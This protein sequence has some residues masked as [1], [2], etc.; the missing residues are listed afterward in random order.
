MFKDKTNRPGQILT[1][2]I[3]AGTVDEGKGVIAHFR[4]LQRVGKAVVH[5]AHIGK[6]AASIA[7]G[8][9][10]A[11]ISL[12]KEQARIC[13]RRV[14]GFFRVGIDVIKD[15]FSGLGAAFHV[16]GDLHRLVGVNLR[17][18]CEPQFSQCISHCNNR[19]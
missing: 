17:V 2:G 6:S 12:E 10:F 9:L 3:P 13:L 1:G 5:R 8:K 16:I 11:G 19:N 14:G 7:D 18:P 4:K 15:R